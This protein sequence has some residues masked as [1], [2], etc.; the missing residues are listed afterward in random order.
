M[1]RVYSSQ[2]EF[3]PINYLLKPLDKSWRILSL[4][5][6]QPSYLVTQRL[7]QQPK[8]LIQ[9]YFTLNLGLYIKEIP[10]ISFVFEQN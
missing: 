1:Y 4:I 3:I 6:N 9:Y 10:M 8:V 7:K 5:V 2:E